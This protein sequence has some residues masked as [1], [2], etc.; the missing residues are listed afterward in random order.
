VGSIS[1]VHL[2]SVSTCNTNE[3][4]AHRSSHWVSGPSVLSLSWQSIV[5]KSLFEPSFYQD[6]L[7]PNI[8][9]TQK[10]RRSEISVANLERH[11]HH[12][13]AKQPV[14]VRVRAVLNKLVEYALIRTA[15]KAAASNT[16]ECQQLQLTLC[17][18]RSRVRAAG[19]EG[20]TTLLRCKSNEGQQQPFRVYQKRGHLSRQ[21]RDI[22]T[23]V[24]EILLPVF[25]LDL[26]PHNRSV[27]VG[28]GARQALLDR[29]CEM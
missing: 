24:K 16:L 26:I 6:R 11:L 22:R 15:C 5:L 21:A 23:A 20:T 3:N 4:T 2:N 13:R 19:S 14:L 18:N 12:L 7:G 28:R 29:F 10:K 17:S 27:G 25:V 1:H 9:K 8:G